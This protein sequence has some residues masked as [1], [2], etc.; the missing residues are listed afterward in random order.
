MAKER[1][2][3]LKGKAGR[4]LRDVRI[5][6][7]PYKAGQMVA[8]PPKQADA[9]QKDGSLDTHPDAVSYALAQGEQGIVHEGV[10]SNEDEASPDPTTAPTP[11]PSSESGPGA[12]PETS[13]AP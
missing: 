12:E 1:P 7:V 11:A 5:D 4:I 9:L 3:T 10:D 2:K 8:F 13:Q 6:G